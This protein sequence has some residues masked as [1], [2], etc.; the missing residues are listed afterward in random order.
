MN[1]KGYNV[2]N[3]GMKTVAIRGRWKQKVSKRLFKN[4]HQKK[5]VSKTVVSYTTS[6][7]EVSGVYK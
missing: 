5:K 6:N 3:A 2:N 1:H 7:L 4:K